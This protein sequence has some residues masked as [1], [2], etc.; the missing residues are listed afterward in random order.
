MHKTA[1]SAVFSSEGT[2]C[3]LATVLAATQYSFF[4]SCLIMN[5]CSLDVQVLLLP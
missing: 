2:A 5:A 4:P 1:S 3:P